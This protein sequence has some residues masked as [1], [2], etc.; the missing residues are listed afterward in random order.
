[1]KVVSAQMLMY[2]ASQGLCLKEEPWTGSPGPALPLCGQLPL[3]TRLG[4]LAV[5]VCHLILQAPQLWDLGP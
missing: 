3:P 2:L 1:M 5:V 4:T